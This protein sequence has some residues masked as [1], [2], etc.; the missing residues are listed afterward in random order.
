MAF[1]KRLIQKAVQDKSLRVKHSEIGVD[2]LMPS[3]ASDEPRSWQKSSSQERSGASNSSI[4][5]MELPIPSGHLKESQVVPQL[6]VHH[7][8][9]HTASI[10]AYEPVQRLLAVA[11]SDGR[12]KILGAVGVEG[13]FHSS[14]CVPC[15]FL[16][17]LNNRGL[18]VHVNTQND[19]EVWDVEQRE[20]VYWTKWE[21]EITSFNVLQGSSFMFL[22]D[23]TGTVFVLQFVYDDQQPQ[24]AIMPY[25][26]PAHVTLGGLVRSGSS[27]APSVIGVLPQPDV[28]YTRLLV[29]YGNG[30]IILWGLHE[31]QVLAVR[32]GTEDQR[33]QLSN[34]SDSLKGRATASPSKHEATDEEE[35]VKE[36]CCVSWAC[37]VGSVLAVG[38]TDGEIFL[39]SFPTI[40]SGN[41]Q[42]EAEFVEG[43]V[44]SGELLHKVDLAP[45]KAKM[46][47]VGLIWGA[48]GKSSSRRIG[49]RL[50]VFGGREVGQSEALTILSLD[51]LHGQESASKL[52]QLELKLQ[53]P[54]AD[55]AL[56][57]APG[58]IL[59]TSAA[60][61]VLLMMP[62]LLHVFDELSIG[63]YF[64]GLV[65]GTPSAAIP[66]PVPL[67][68][69]LTESKVTCA[70]LVLVSNDGMAARLLRQLPETKQS[71]LPSTLPGGTR[72]PIS[73]GALSA[74]SSGQAGEENLYITG[75]ENGLVKVWDASS[76]LYSLLSKVETQSDLAKSDQNSVS[77]VE[78]CPMSG[79]LA[80]GSENGTVFVY[81]LSKEAHQVKCSIIEESSSKE[82]LLDCA[83]GFGCFLI[84]NIHKS[85]ITTI[86]IASGPSRIAIGD[87]GGMVSLLDL[88]SPSVTFYDYCFPKNPSPILAV[89]FSSGS[90]S[91]DNTPL[92]PR[93]PRSPR[94][95][96]SLSRNRSPPVAM[97][98]SI[99]LYAVGKDASMVAMDGT[100]GVVFGS[101]AM[102][103]KNPSTAVSLHLLDAGGAPVALL[104]RQVDETCERGDLADQFEPANT[105][106]SSVESASLGGTAFE[107]QSSDSPTCETSSEAMFLLLC[108]TDSLRLYATHAVIQGQRTTLCKV[109]LDITCSWTSTF[110]IKGGRESG[111]ILMSNTGDLEFRSLPDLGLLKGTSLSTVFDCKAEPS[112]D[113][114]KTMACN[115]KGE[116]VMVDHESELMQMSVL[117]QNDSRDQVSLARLYDKDLAKAADAAITYARNAPRR[118]SQTPIQGMQGL[119]GGVLKELRNVLDI[120]QQQVVHFSSEL[121]KLFSTSPFNIVSVEPKISPQL[122]ASGSSHSVT[123]TTMDIDDIDME[124]PEAEVAQPPPVEISKANKFTN[125]LTGALKSLKGKERSDSPESN[126]MKLFDGKDEPKPSKAQTVDDIR[127]KYGHPRKSQEI[128]SALDMARNKLAERGEKLQDIG[129]KTAE[130]EDNAQNFASMAEELAKKMAQRKWW[131][132]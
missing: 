130:M 2:E 120:D 32:G 47:V 36:I 46:P 112:V 30:L 60:A 80:V 19:I 9:P 74:T 38:Y 89:S 102:Q 63:N 108:C 84:Q 55:M 90:F 14:S 124:Y 95:S 35:E 21:D 69:P 82:E 51:S 56:L 65:E 121:P 7:G 93:S 79:L 117:E 34:F 118:K 96:N 37:P 13:L 91:E 20:L 73:G 87:E 109:K 52:L 40:I 24:F 28:F 127:A 103:P 115:T 59:T 61:L 11:S 15:K 4:P 68:L 57:P 50:Y 29:A 129:D 62:G 114:Q 75:H 100:T 123:D 10:I 106:T 49:G 5:V 64:N 12:I 33:L 132:L 126:R 86:A 104:D 77:T 119:L 88:Q 111:L 125:K 116:L 44:Y 83:P 97:G 1:V 78:F 70:K 43:P 45:E 110:S 16:E 25:V 18:L 85:A 81:R 26:I 39:W 76:L 71:H 6:A 72:W 41:G 22:G 105:A 94:L 122:E 53:G 99:V 23:Q 48:S 27:D 3:P 98:R 131:E 66:Q 31:T 92:S 128:S 17:F 8:I 113:S 101:G 58:G 42:T 67:Q 54:F 107:G